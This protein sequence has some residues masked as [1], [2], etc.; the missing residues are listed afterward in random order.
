MANSVYSSLVLQTRFKVILDQVGL[1]IEVGSFTLDFSAV[2]SE[3][4]TRIDQDKALG[5]A[6]LIDFNRATQGLLQDTAWID[7]GRELLAESLAALDDATELAVLTQWFGADIN[8]IIVG[9]A[10]AAGLTGGVGHDVMLGEAGNDVLVGGL[11]GD[12]LDGGVGNDRLD[13]GAGDDIYIFRRGSGQDV[14]SQWDT[15][16]NK[17]NIVQF[18]LNIRPEDLSLVRSNNNLVISVA[19]SSDVLTIERHFFA[20]SA[21]IDLFKFT[22]GSSWDLTAVKERTI[23]VGTSDGDYILGYDGGSNRVFALEGDDTVFGGDGNDELNG[24]MGADRLTSFAGD[25]ALDGEEGDDVLD[26][27]DGNDIRSGWNR[28][29]RIVRWSWRRFSGRRRRQR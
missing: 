24:G 22:D 25:D 28:C 9:D 29:G 15:L 16:A 11:G 17:H 18:G 20:P 6:D 12:I 14:I 13:G 3:F 8:A 2:L 10:L 5:I 4:Q 21:Q 7:M 23:T 1:T 27:G 26:G 19:N